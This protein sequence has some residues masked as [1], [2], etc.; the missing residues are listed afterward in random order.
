MA[1]DVGGDGGA[2]KK[3]AKKG[4]KK[5]PNPR[6]DMTP[7]VDLGFL[8]LTF[9][10]L[11]TTMATPKS[12]P[13]VLP[14]KEEVKDDKPVDIK[15]SK[16]VHLI[17]GPGNRVFYYQGVADDK[18]EPV[19]IKSELFA[20]NQ[21]EAIHKIILKYREEINAAFPSEKEPSLMLIKLM[22]DAVFQNVVD[23]LDE[24]A[25]NGQ[26]KYAIVEITP[27]EVEIINEYRQNQG[28]K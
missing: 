27:E 16:V 13:I 11:T 3:G 23:M 25:I 10:V 17:L 5:A 9:F 18:G 19:D 8:L 2:P 20:P 24:M 26:E 1:A 4:R 12:M 28:L 22:D 7:M 6:I 14:D 15:A 21:P